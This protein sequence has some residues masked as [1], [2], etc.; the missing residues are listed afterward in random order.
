MV[1]AIGCVESGC[2]YLLP[3]ARIK[4]NDRGVCSIQV[5]VTQ[6][7]EGINGYVV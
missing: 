2:T 4:K 5:S 6:E 1:S 3:E 7:R